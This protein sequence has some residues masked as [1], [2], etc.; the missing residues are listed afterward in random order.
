MIVL[1]SVFNYY[2]LKI[3]VRYKK[4]KEKVL[5]ILFAYF[6]EKEQRTTLQIKQLAE[7]KKYNS[8]QNHMKFLNITILVNCVMS[9]VSIAMFY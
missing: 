1:E 7:N 4:I 8:F 6:I 5:N 9:F 3:G 2:D